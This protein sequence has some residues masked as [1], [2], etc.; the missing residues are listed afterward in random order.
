M[1]SGLAGIL[2]LAGC[3]TIKPTGSIDL[4]LVP[5]RCDDKMM[6]NELMTELDLGVKYRNFTI[7][8]R[9][10]TYMNKVENKLSFDPS[11]QEYDFY[12]N[13]AKDQLKLYFEHMCSNI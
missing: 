8:G 4:A 9:S 6:E 12:T 2:L 5:S 13:Y 3:S 7:G 11:R 1:K 10:R